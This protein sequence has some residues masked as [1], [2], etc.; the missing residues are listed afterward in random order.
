MGFPLSNPTQGWLIPEQSIQGDDAAD[1]RL[2]RMM[3]KQAETFARSQPWCLDLNRGMFVD[4]V[5][6][7]VALFLFEAAISKVTQPEWLWIF[8]GDVPSSYLEYE[9]FRAPKAALL[10]YIEGLEGWIDAARHGMSL[11]E[12]IPIRIEPREEVFELLR[13]RCDAMRK[14]VLPWLSPEPVC[15]VKTN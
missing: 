1:T 9:G 8:V 10:R 7:I 3:S 6:G 14:I 11:E 15:L 12:L 13:I 5:G 4:G 2:L